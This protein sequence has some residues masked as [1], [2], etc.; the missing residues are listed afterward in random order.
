VLG[1][2]P[3]N[4]AVDDADGAI[5][6]SSV[7]TAEV[8]E[9]RPDASVRTVSPGGLALPQGVALTGG[10]RGVSEILV[11]TAAGVGRFTPSGAPSGFVPAALPNAVASLT[12]GPQALS[13]GLFGGAV[14]TF[15]LPAGAS[16]LTVTGLDFPLDAARLRDDVLVAE[17]GTRR[18]LRVSGTDPARR[19]TVLQGAGSPAGLAVRG[20]EAWVTDIE[21][22]RV[23]RLADDG[24]ILRR[25]RTVAT[26]LHRPQ[27]IAAHRRGLVVVEAGA[28]RVVPGRGPGSS[29]AR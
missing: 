4:L 21:G 15:D 14:T 12:A 8:A 17:G 13:A 19:K 26:G 7:T 23:L 3:D 9:V 18:V 25:P 20:G 28:G 6:V 1:F 27:A 29:R 11:A 16:R 10:P 22:G 24:R 2:L 5:L